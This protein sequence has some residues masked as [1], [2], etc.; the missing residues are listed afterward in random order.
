ML[1][2]RV[3]GDKGRVFGYYDHIRRRGGD[4]F[5]LKDVAHFSAAYMEEMD[6]EAFAEARAAV[7]TVKGKLENLDVEFGKNDTMK[8]L[9]VLLEGAEK[10]APS[11]KEATKKDDAVDREAVK[12]KLKELE[13]GFAGN[14][15]TV[16]LVALLEEAE[17]AKGEAAKTAGEGE[18]S[19]EDEK[20]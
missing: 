1:K 4:E 20:E 19:Q 15:S 10:A 8:A 5:V 13:V 12:A 16:K 7:A 14:L 18:G 11:K 2:V 17:K 6:K 9:A 3:K